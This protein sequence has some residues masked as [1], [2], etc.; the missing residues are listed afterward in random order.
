MYELTI[1]T[2]TCQHCVRTITETVQRLDPQA[3]LEVDL[4]AHRV[5]ISS[6]LPRPVFDAALAEEGYAPA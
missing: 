5:A 2:M 6:D 4:A 3:R 1:P